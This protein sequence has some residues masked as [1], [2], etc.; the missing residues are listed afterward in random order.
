MADFQL[1]LSEVRM[2]EDITLALVNAST[3]DDF[4]LQID[5]K[6]IIVKGKSSF[7]PSF[8]LCLT[9]EAFVTELMVITMMRSFL[10][11]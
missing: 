3:D 8:S 10:F 4:Y 2:P 11:H 6:S 9:T 1:D 5:T 7:P